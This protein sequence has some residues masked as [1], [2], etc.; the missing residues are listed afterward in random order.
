MTNLNNQN[1]NDLPTDQE[2]L[3]F[4]EQ[5]KTLTNHALFLRFNTLNNEYGKLHSEIFN[6]GLKGILDRKGKNLDYTILKD[7]A[8]E[9][10]KTLGT[11]RE[12]FIT[13]IPIENQLREPIG[14]VIFAEIL[15]VSALFKYLSGKW[16]IQT[17]SVY[18]NEEDNNFNQYYFLYEEYVKKAKELEK[19]LPMVDNQNILYEKI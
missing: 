17:G 19:L 16:E 5:T 8:Y 12:L 7:Q 11:F 6:R 4:Q 2:K 13:V 9:L 14:D 15:A 1:P 3:E 10:F 18:S